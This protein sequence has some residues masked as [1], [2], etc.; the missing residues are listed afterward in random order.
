MYKKLKEIT[1]EQSNGYVYKY[2][3]KGQT[4]TSVNKNFAKEHTIRDDD[5][6][7]DKK[8]LKDEKPS[9]YYEYY[10]EKSKNE[11]FHIK[12]NLDIK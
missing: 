9:L 5:I 10:V 12:D 3:K 11:I 7:I 8:K 1:P 2:N 6:I 4:K